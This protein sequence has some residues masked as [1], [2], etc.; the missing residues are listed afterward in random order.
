MAKIP[1][2]KKTGGWWMWLLALL[3][4]LLLGWMLA[5]V[6]DDED[7]LDMATAEVET[8]EP[9]ETEVDVGPIT[10]LVVLASAP[11]W[12]DMLEREVQLTDLRV[13]RVVG[14]K[15]FYVVPQGMQNAEELLIVLDQVPTPGQPGIEGRYDVT[16]GQIMTIEGELRE[17]D[18]DPVQEWQL[19][20]AEAQTLSSDEI[21]VHADQL[22][23]Q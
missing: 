2:E 1:V 23:I 11:S 19:T 9:V 3:A 14:D 18:V 6:L 16:A 7:D 12:R 5:E 17:L 15:T 22:D 4:L 10:S 13:T 21:Y 20:E 8:V